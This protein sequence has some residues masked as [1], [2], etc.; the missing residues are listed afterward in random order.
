ML[1][2]GTDFPHFLRSMRR[3]PCVNSCPVEALSISKE[4]GAVLVNKEKCI[5]CGKCIEAC[6]GRIPHMH[7]S[8]KHILIC[9]LCSGDPQCVKV[10][11]EG[12]W[13]VLFTTERRGH[14]YKLY[15]RKPE[16]VARSLA[17]KMYGEEGEKLI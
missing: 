13:N 10:C 16:E 5:A 9:D 15:A 17:V 12:K 14:P 4:T 3:Y 8:A 1:V 6:P 7:P 11:Q 2:P